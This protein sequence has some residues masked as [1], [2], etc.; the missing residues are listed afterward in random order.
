MGGDAR[1]L[2]RHLE[3]GAVEPLGLVQPARLV[4]PDGLRQQGF[5]VEAGE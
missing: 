3:R 1:V 2:G 5:R 4:R